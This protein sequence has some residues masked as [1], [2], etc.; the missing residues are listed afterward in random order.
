MSIATGR[1]RLA[2]RLT[3]LGAV[4][5][6]VTACSGA[7]GGGITIKDAWARTSPMVAGAGA[8]YMVIANPGS[9][10]DAVVGGSA[11]F[12]KAVEVHETVAMGSAAPMASPSMGGG[13]AS[14]AAS[15]GWRRAA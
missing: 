5:V 10:A 8:A 4:V 13:M 2:A 11:D 6:L 14:P 9:A 3:A 1:R 7:S 15:G 12:A